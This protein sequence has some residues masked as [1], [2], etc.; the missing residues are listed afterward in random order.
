MFNVQFTSEPDFIRWV[1]QRMEL[2]PDESTIALLQK[3]EL[4]KR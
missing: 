3:Y 2:F 1:K 4:S